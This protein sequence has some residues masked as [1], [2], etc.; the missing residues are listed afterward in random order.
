MG[1]LFFV[2][3]T[4][5]AVVG[6]MTGARPQVKLEQGIV[7]GKE[8]R[9]R[10]T[11]NT[12]LAFQG[13]PYA[14]P[15]LGDLRFKD[16]LPPE[17]WDGVL[18]ADNEGAD[19][20]Q[21]RSIS[22]RAVVGKEDCLFLNVYTKR[23][24][25]DDSFSPRAVMVWIHGGAFIAGSGST[26]MYGPDYLVEE[27][28]VVVT[29]NYRLG[30]LGF[31]SLYDPE[32]P[33]N[34]G[35]KDQV[36]ALKWVQKNIA[37]FGGDPNSVTIFGESAGAASVHLLTLSPM[38]QG[39]FK[40]AICQSGSALN[41]WAFKKS[42]RANVKILAE[43]AGCKDLETKALAACL[44]EVSARKL[45][46]LSFFASISEEDKRV[47]IPLPFAPTVDTTFLPREPLEILEDGDFHKVPFLAGANDAEGLLMFN[48]LM[49][50]Q[51]KLKILNDDFERFVP[52]DLNLP[53]GSEES[54]EVAEMMK[55]FYLDG[56]PITQDNLNDYKDLSTDRL[57]LLGIHRTFNIQANFSEE[58]MY[59]Y[60]MVY[61]GRL[62]FFK[63]YLGTTT[64]EGVCHADE[65][66]YLWYMSLFPYKYPE[67]SSETRTLRRMVSMWTNFAKTGDPTPKE[68]ELMNVKWK[69]YTLE[70]PAYLVIDSSLKMDTHIEKK[71]MDFWDD[72]YAKFGST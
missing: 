22:G 55:T 72:L 58:P 49:A 38:T 36:E 35:L 54:L 16:P 20:L 28:V 41:P 47:E 23:L 50:H 52:R 9:S 40:R 15:P 61:E 67:K 19:C 31:L 33:G 14:K 3:A 68:S 29:I 10:A 39:L 24:P 32:V 17:P 57:F 43:K 65:M 11:S 69:P 21:T 60:L 7:K 27:D 63:R 48:I 59:Q 42:V 4:W 18:D 44:R 51:R 64:M 30:V 2:M 56:Q 5:L 12:F 6:Q 26:L 66:G 1:L 8:V 34:M 62:G 71:R 70:D 25:T 13:I 46:A 53:W 37:Q 45:A